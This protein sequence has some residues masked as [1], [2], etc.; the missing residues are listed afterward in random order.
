MSIRDI[1]EKERILAS[2]DP[3]ELDLLHFLQNLGS[4][5]LGIRLKSMPQ[6]VNERSEK[7]GYSNQCIVV[8]LLRSH[9]A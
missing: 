9:K 3:M 7:E 6:K 8:W 2:Q 4:L 1:F 5:G